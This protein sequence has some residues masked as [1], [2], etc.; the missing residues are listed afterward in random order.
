MSDANIQ[1]YLGQVKF[2]GKKGYGFITAV[3]GP[4]KDQD[5]FVH[6]SAI[7]PLYSTYRTLKRGEYV[8]FAIVE[9][10]TTPDRK[11]AANVTG[12]RGYPLMCDVLYQMH[13]DDHPSSR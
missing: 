11:H 8:E 6:H 13:N 12:V 1:R 5:V 3:E 7:E 9:N 2:F 4:Q 10:T